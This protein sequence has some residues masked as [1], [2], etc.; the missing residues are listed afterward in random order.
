V[1]ILLKTHQLPVIFV[2]INSQMSTF[3]LFCFSL[4]FL[5][6]IVLWLVNASCSL[7]Y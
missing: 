4:F 6:L 2:F 3:F 7:L 5:G 1:R